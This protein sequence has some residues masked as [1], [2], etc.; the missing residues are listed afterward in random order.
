MNYPGTLPDNEN[1]NALLLNQQS[2]A[3]DA[4]QQQQSLQQVAQNSQVQAQSMDSQAISAIMDRARAAAAAEATPEL[5]A[6][7]MMLNSAA[8]IQGMTPDGGRAKMAI[9]QQGTEEI[10]RRIYG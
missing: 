6:K 7:A 8:G 5:K 9:A 2:G 1:I 3:P 10:A 4:Y